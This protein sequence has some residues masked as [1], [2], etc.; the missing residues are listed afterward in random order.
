MSKV[1]MGESPYFIHGD[2]VILNDEKNFGIDVK[3]LMNVLG[4][5]ITP[6]TKNILVA[7]NK[8]NELNKDGK[9]K[10]NDLNENDFRKIGRMNLWWPCTHDPSE[11][12]IQK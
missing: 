12:E 11:F 7:F 1:N 8:I 9:I 4:N 10:N 5:Q 2:A 3:S 6:N